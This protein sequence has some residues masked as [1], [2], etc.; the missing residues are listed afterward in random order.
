MSAEIKTIIDDLG[1]TFEGFKKNIIERHEE[2]EK[3]NRVDSIRE[4]EI[5]KKTAALINFDDAKERLE[6][7]ASD[8]VLLKAKAAE[9]EE[10]L[11][12][13]VF[14]EGGQKT[15]PPKEIKEA[16]Q[17][18]LRKG[19][20]ADLQTVNEF[21]Q[22]QHKS[23]NLTNADEGGVFYS[24]TNDNAIEPLI[25]E[26][27]P[28]RQVCDVKTISTSS[29]TFKRKTGNTDAGWIAELGTRADTD[30]MTYA[31][32]EIVTHECY[33]QPLI[34]QKMLEDAEFD[35]EGEINEDLADTFAD[36]ENIS[37]ISGNGVGRPRGLLTHTF[38]STEV[39]DT[40][41]YVATGASGD[42]ASTDPHL[43]LLG[44]G[45]LL[46]AQFTANSQWMMSRG[47]VAEVMK[48]VDA[49]KRP[50]WQPSMQAG[51]PSALA[52]YPIVKNENMPAKAA[53]SYSVL[54]GDFKRSYRI[55]DR[56]GTMLLR[57]PFTSK[58]YVK[59]YTTRRVGGD[60]LRKDAFLAFKFA[61]S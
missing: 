8:V 18:Y 1:R 42:W 47:R 16:M 23:L 49:E 17:R 19:S 24:F 33:A 37:F 31:Q 57:D 51:T 55:V 15:G 3:N 61:A 41:L 45:E 44:V 22:L 29:Y 54:F 7:A 13:P 5:A 52:G 26:I 2:F 20:L 6:K 56:R 40:V 32:Q 30:A 46:K 60:V 36:L 59:M 10:R 35:V 43:K 21:V 14:T 12:Q 38:S 48:F 53:N 27:A 4:N 34:S 58:G 28:M 39:A 11:N 25:R 50:L 9:L